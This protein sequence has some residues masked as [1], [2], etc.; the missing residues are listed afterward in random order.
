MADSPLLLN[1]RCR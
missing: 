1:W